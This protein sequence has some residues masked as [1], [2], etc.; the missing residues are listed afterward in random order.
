MEV[1]QYI[2]EHNNNL[3]RMDKR[4][5][6]YIYS[7]ILSEKAISLFFHLDELINNSLIEQKLNLTQLLLLLN[8]KPNE[9]HAL[10]RKLEAV[11][12]LR[13]YESQ[14]YKQ[15]ILEMNKPMHPQKIK[16]NKLFSKEIIKKIGEENFELLIEN[17]NEKKIDKSEYEEITAKFYEEFKLDTNLIDTTK[18]VVKSNS[19][20]INNID[21]DEAKKTLDFERYIEF[22]TKAP[23]LPSIS[24][25]IK[26]YLKSGF[27]NYALNEIS[28]FCFEVNGKVNF[29]YFEKVANT[30][31]ADG[32][33]KAE[34]IKVE[35]EHKMLYKKQNSSLIN[36]SK[37]SLENNQDDEEGVKLSVEDLV[38]NI[39]N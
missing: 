9:F 3:T 11:G 25:K 31:I 35:L 19:H 24:N 20:S 2:L 21:P 6:K 5:V 18:K 33:L 16:N 14:L 4:V 30:L 38:Y 12:L 10:R 13:T 28:Y 23:I 29:K 26:K 34:D 15:C 22:L 36:D 37:A 39:E 1:K 8:L 7:I 32:V 17:F 27:D